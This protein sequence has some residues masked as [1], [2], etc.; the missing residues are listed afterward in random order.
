MKLT[1]WNWITLLSPYLSAVLVLYLLGKIGM[2][3]SFLGVLIF[4]YLFVVFLYFAPY[5]EQ[6][7]KTGRSFKTKYGRV[8]EYETKLTGG[9]IDSGK[10]AGNIILIHFLSMLTCIFIFFKTSDSSSQTFTN[11]NKTTDS[12][13]VEPHSVIV[14]DTNSNNYEMANASVAQQTGNDINTS[15]NSDSTEV[16]N[17]NNIEESDYSNL[18]NSYFYGNW[19]DEN[20]SIFF[21]KN[22]TCT[23]TVDNYKVNYFWKYENN[24]LYMGSDK[25]SL[26]KHDIY[27]ISSNSFSY[28]A[29]NENLIYHAKRIN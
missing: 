18:I 13:S 29:E 27:T 21:N 7:V 24:Y 20:S 14:T 28:K 17:Q 25:S 15:E 3:P 19:E 23:V 2:H 10:T 1:T 5:M 22:G 4:C 8:D 9:T 16:S 12:T 11:N 6:D 26:T